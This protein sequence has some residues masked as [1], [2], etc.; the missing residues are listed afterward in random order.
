VVKSN[1]FGVNIPSTTLSKKQFADRIYDEMQIH[2]E[3]IAD[4]MFPSV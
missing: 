1:F 4:D 2:N 3:H